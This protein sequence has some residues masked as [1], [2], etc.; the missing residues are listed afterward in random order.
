MKPDDTPSADISW[1]SDL[2]SRSTF[3]NGRLS[4]VVDDN[5]AGTGIYLYS[6]PTDPD[7]LTIE[8]DHRNA[9]ITP[10]IR[11]VIHASDQVCPID[12]THTARMYLLEGDDGAAVYACPDC[13]TWIT[14]KVER[15]TDPGE[16]TPEASSDDSVMWN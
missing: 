9:G 16:S 15:R 12:Y 2:P 10:G 11:R 6:P 5:G 8:A 7:F 1:S 14:A 3:P 13:M 4:E